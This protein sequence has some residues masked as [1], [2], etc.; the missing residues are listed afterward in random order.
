MEQIKTLES[1]MSQQKDRKNFVEH[2]DLKVLE[3]HLADYL[4]LQTESNKDKDLQ[5]V[6]LRIS[7]LPQLNV[8]HQVCSRWENYSKFKKWVFKQEQLALKKH[9]AA[10]ETA[11]RWFNAQEVINL[12]LGTFFTRNYESI[13]TVVAC[14]CN[15]KNNGL[16]T[17]NRFI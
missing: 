16:F 6:S 3:Q 13:L 15:E 1:F 8:R 11:V 9:L 14:K 4:T 10:A 7:K 5:N 2:D 17:G 12:S